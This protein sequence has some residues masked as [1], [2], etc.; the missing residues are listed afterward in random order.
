MSS[1]F[2]HRFLFVRSFQTLVRKMAEKLTFSAADYRSYIK[3]CI[4]LAKSVSEILTNARALSKA[5]APSKATVFKWVKH[6]S[7][8]Q[9]DNQDSYKIRNKRRNVLLQIAEGFGQ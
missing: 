9:L 2:V 5:S 8:R 1:L 4:A 7:G 6:F 3:V